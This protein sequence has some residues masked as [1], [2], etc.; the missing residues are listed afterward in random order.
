M[1]V[2]A[3]KWIPTIIRRRKQSAL[4]KQLPNHARPA[5]HPRDLAQSDRSRVGRRLYQSE[6]FREGLSA[7]DRGDTDRVPHHP[8]KASAALILSRKNALGRAGSG[9]KEQARCRIVHHEN[10][11]T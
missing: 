7:I 4:S 8:L 1:T 5:A 10:T 9:E 11:Q 3:E 6:P 2:P